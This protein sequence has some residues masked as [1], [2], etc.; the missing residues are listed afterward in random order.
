MRYAFWLGLG[1][2]GIVGSVGAAEL[3]QKLPPPRLEGGMPLMQALNSR[4][5]SR[6]L[7]DRQVPLQVLSDLLWAA[8]GVNRPETGKRTAP[9]ARDWR[10]IDIYVTRADGVQVYQPE[11]HSLR[12]ISQRDVRAH[13][14]RQEYPAKAPVNLVYVADYARMKEV[15]DEQRAFY[16]ATDTGFMAQNV[17]LYCAAAGL[18]CVVRGAVDRDALAVAL[19]LGPRQRITLAQTIGY[20]R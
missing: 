15:D 5:S 1:I 9:T 3:E 2:M 20:P 13:T 11:S 18:G 4:H 8:G 19:G 14:G 7:S 6:E 17:Y 16:A 10:E 12:R